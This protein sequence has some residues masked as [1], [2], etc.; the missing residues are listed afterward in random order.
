MNKLIANQFFEFV[1]SLFVDEIFR[2]YNEFWKNIVRF[3]IRSIWKNT[4]FF[5]EQ[6]LQHLID[7]EICEILFYELF[8]SI[9]NAKFDFVYL[10]L[11]EMIAI[12]KNYS[13]TL[14]HYF[15]ENLIVL[16]KIRKNFFIEKKLR[17]I[18]FE[19]NKINEQNISFFIS[20]MQFEKL[21]NMNR[22]IAKKKFDNMNVFYKIRVFSFL[23][24]FNI[25][26]WS[27]LQW[28]FF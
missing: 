4:K 20:I 12:Y 14:N 10:K 25:D 28:K 8:E 6:I 16:Q 22:K 26:D 18:F 21:F 1:N 19:R 2:K 13:I 24:Y 7:I 11:N 17:E 15:Q 3:Y 23:H 5:I 27:K 9:M